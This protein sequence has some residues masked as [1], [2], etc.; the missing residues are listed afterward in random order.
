MNIPAEQ[1][2]VSVFE[3]DNE[4]YEIW[5]TD[6]KLPKEKIYRLG[7]SENFWQMGDTG[8]CG[9]CSEIHI[10][11]GKGCGKKTCDPSCDCGRFME[12]WNLVFMQF[13][14]Q[15]NGN[16]MSLTQ[17]G[18]DTGMGFERLATVMQNVDTVF[19]TDLFTPLIE[20]TEKL[21][22]KK[23]ADQSAEIKT[24][25]HVLADHIRSSSFTIADGAMPSNEGRGYVLRKIIRRAA[26]FERK[27]IKKSIFVQLVPSLVRLM[28]PVYPELKTNE[29]LI[30]RVLESEIKKFAIN[31]ER[32]EPILERIFHTHKQDKKIPGKDTFKLY[33]TYGFPIE[34]VI[35]RAKENG[36]TIDMIGFEKE[37]EKQRQQSRK[38]ETT[39]LSISLDDSIKT[40]FIGYPE[41]KKYNL[42]ATSPIIALVTDNALVEKVSPGKSA[43]I[44]TKESP[45]FVESGGQIS[46]LGWLEF[47]G[48]LFP[49]EEAQKINRAIAIRITPSSELQIGDQI[50]TIIDTDYRENIMRNH[51]ATHLLQAT[52]VELFGSHIKQAGSLVAADYLRFDFNYH[53]QLSAAEIK[54][55]E[56]RVNQKIMENIPLHIF[57]TTYDEAIKRGIT[58]IFG[59]KYNPE[60][61]RVIE[62]PGFSAE[63]CGGI[64]VVRTGSIGSFK[65]SDISALAAGTRRNTA[66]TGKPALSLF[67]ETFATVKSLSQE[68]KVQPHQVIEA[69]EKQKKEIKKLQQHLKQLKKQSLVAQ[70]P[71]WINQ[72]EEINEIP[73]LA[74]S[75]NGYTV[76]ELKDITTTLMK[77]KAGFYF[78]LSGNESRSIFVATVDSTLQKK[79]RLDLLKRWLDENFALSGGGNDTLLQGGGTAVSKSLIPS[80]KEWIKKQ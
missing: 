73:F 1:L 65:I 45:L 19:E 28:A 59:E 53:Q 58:A 67:Q 15:P 55:I 56:D 24:A 31:L 8:P 18:V 10:D 50:T 23:Y 60:S 27:L 69:I 63:L 51:T 80:L 4:A 13:D 32:G 39:K 29:S 3:S 42:K 37:M 48:K 16:D 5:H 54:Q 21:T 17:T 11:R 75:V 34:L 36:F 41:L 22:G 76:Q 20:A 12:I 79:I 52:L 47:K 6:I 30:M 38:Q 72:I 2:V 35:A 25:F 44:I 26:L 40:E 71:L 62:I 46:D 78:L 77:Q 61:V 64:H 70:I 14:R 33:D 43:W 7:A 9:P 49:I 68:F 74:L 57:E 66:L